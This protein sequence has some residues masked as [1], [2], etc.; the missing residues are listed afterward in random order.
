LNKRHLQLCI[1]SF[2][3]AV[4]AAQ[5]ACRHRSAP[6]RADAEQR[7]SAEQKFTT[8]LFFIFYNSTP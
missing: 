2:A 1:S 8:Q 3:W 5:A 7:L 4:Q 6:W